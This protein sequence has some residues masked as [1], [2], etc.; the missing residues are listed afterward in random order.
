LSFAIASGDALPLS[1]AVCDSV[2]CN[3]VYEHVRDANALMAEIVRVLRPGGACWFA[4]GH[5]W[6]LIEPH[7]RLPLLSLMPRRLASAVVRATGRDSAYEVRFLAPWR[8][9]E[10]FVH[11]AEARLVSIDALRAPSQYELS[12][13]ALRFSPVR[14]LVRT[15]ARPLA[16]L[17]PTQLWIL[18]K[19]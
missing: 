13:G 18:R 8:V 12:V 11:F 4:A 9:P 6:Q 10:L 14:T 1:D 5:T 15:F 7:Y 3:H 16:W 19:R 2:V 17:S